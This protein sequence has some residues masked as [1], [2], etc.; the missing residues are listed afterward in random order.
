MTPHRPRP[1]CAICADREA[2]T[3]TDWELRGVMRE[4]PACDVCLAPVPDPIE[5][6][7]PVGLAACVSTR[8]ALA[9]RG[10]KDSTLRDA[11]MA[12]VRQ[13]GTVTSKELQAEFAMLDDADRCV[14]AKSLS[15]MVDRGQL[16]AA[17][18]DDA[19]RSQGRSFRAVENP[20]VQC[21]TTAPGGTRAAVIA[22]VRRLGAASRRRIVAELAAAGNPS[23]ANLIG[24]HLRRLEICGAMVLDGDAYRLT[25][26]IATS[27]AT[28]ATAGVLEA[29]PEEFDTFAIDPDH[30]RAAVIARAWLQEGLVSCVRAKRDS[31]VGGQRVWFAALWRK[32]EQARRAA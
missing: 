26:S 29:L 11:I 22:A 1:L 18:V 4:V 19:D 28:A 30:K 31:T 16:V 15:R 13:R 12:A 2:T 10:C 17:W 5:A 23:S 6:F 24:K 32:T 14:L 27:Q 21:A 3:A 7:E 20:P 8:P 9:K 25:G